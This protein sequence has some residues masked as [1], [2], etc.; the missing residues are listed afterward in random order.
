MCPRTLTELI[1]GVDEPR[2]IV[3]ASFRR[4]NMLHISLTPLLPR[5]S[6][7]HG[8]RAPPLPSANAFLA[9][10][11]SRPLAPG[12]LDHPRC[13]FRG[14]TLLAASR[15]RSTTRATHI[16]HLAMTAS[17]SRETDPK[18]PSKTP[19]EFVIANKFIDNL[20][21]AFLNNPE[22]LNPDIIERLRNPPEYTLE[23]DPDERLS[24]DLFLSITNASE[25]HISPLELL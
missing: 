22:E 17:P 20:K 11:L 19:S 21:N 3:R 8:Q 24:I 6:V 25:K 5:G 7:G 4:T 16:L 12:T 10:R 13:S 18:K 14:V 9:F 2:V 23:L 1:L 15:G